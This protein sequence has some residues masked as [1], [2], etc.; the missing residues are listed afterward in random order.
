MGA[1]GKFKA[2]KTCA[3]AAMTVCCLSRLLIEALPGYFSLLASLSGAL[4]IIAFGLFLT[5]YREP[6]FGIGAK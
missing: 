5:A 1:D 6:L 4:W 3:L 2:F